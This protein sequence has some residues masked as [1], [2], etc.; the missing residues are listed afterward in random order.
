VYSNNTLSP[1]CNQTLAENKV[2]VFRNTTTVTHI[3]QLQKGTQQN[4]DS[5][6][7]DQTE[8]KAPSDPEE[9]Q[10]SRLLYHTRET[11]ASA[12]NHQ[13]RKH[14]EVLADAET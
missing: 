6:Q 2:A 8:K 5:I 3:L 12:Q 9:Q 11:T 14:G 4:T 10:G 1:P 13:R 7:K